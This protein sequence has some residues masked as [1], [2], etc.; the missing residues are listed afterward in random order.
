M[1]V[2]LSSCLVMGVDVAH[3][4]FG[5]TCQDYKRFRASL[6]KRSSPTWRD[7]D[8]WLHQP[9]QVREGPNPDFSPYDEDNAEDRENRNELVEF[10]GLSTQVDYFGCEDQEMAMDGMYLAMPFEKE[11]ED[12]DTCTWKL[13]P[14]AE[15]L[16]ALKV[17]A[18]ILGITIKKDDW[19]VTTTASYYR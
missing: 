2:S 11:L 5:P 17:L 9:G 13:R 8:T 3:V 18:R 1:A 15:G 12:E 16:E 7:F 10:F 19:A 14:T 4:D 6:P